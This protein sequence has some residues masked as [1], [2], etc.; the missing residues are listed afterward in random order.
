MVTLSQDLKSTG[1][2]VRLTSDNRR[3]NAPVWSPD[4]RQIIFASDRN[5][6]FSLWRI[7]PEAR[8]NPE[9]ISSVGQGAVALALARR[10]AGGVLRMAYV[11]S[12]AVGRDIYQLSLAGP[13][14][15]IGTAVKVISSTRDENSP[16]YSPDGRKLAF[17]S[18]ASGS[19]E[20]WV[21]DSS[22]SKPVQL[23]SFGGPV[24][25]RPA[26]SPDGKKIA[27]HSRPEG[28]AEIYLIDSDGGQPRR[29]THDPAE[30]V[31]PSWSRDGRWIY[32][33]SRRTGQHQ[34]WK[35][36]AGGGPA[37]QVTQ[38]GGITALE[39]PDG[40][41]LYYTKQRGA[42]SLWKAPTTGGP[43]VKVAGPLFYLKLHGWE[44]WHISDIG[45]PGSRV[46]D[47]RS[48]A[49]AGIKGIPDGAQPC[50]HDL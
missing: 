29:M 3:V 17:G 45:R 31:L 24:T 48:G 27:F 25:D 16:A 46:G 2:P 18:Q 38:N 22:G 41:F 23:T 28:Q 12:Q 4:G 20:I 14:A 43:E 7:S 13:D 33:G 9:H 49:P 42:S 44:E 50:L 30:D 39:S 19:Y 8:G 40:Q 32:F 34:I 21:S 15:P 35:V 1:E 37:T 36:P 10:P 5:G 6:S 47:E 11:D 26:W